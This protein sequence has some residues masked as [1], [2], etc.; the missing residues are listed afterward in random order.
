MGMMWRDRTEKHEA[1]RFLLVL[2]VILREDICSPHARPGRG[3]ECMI[4]ICFRKRA[5][6]LEAV[7]IVSSA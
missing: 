5:R 4:T 6:R 3:G 7:M 1:L 2:V